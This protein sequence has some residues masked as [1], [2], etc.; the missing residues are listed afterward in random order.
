VK[1]TILAWMT[2]LAVAV[3]PAAAWAQH[4]HAPA[5]AP[6]APAPAGEP[7]D[8]EP[9]EGLEEDWLAL[10]DDGEWWLDQEGEVGGDAHMVMRNAHRAAGRGRA[11]L[12]HGR[13]HGMGMVGRFMRLDLTDAQRTKL[14]DLHEAA[15][16]KS[17]QRRAD[18]ELARMDLHKLMRAEN[19]NSASVS[20]A[21]DKVARLH[22]EGLKARF[23]TYMQA[24]AV[25]T[26]EQRK[27][28]DSP[29]GR[30]GAPAA[31]KGEG[32]AK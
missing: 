10:A 20:S 24:R 18:A 25:L 15:A 14:R 31:P 3:L 7:M 19:P 21:I 8:L 32:S 16:R 23:D 28:L 22:A 9:G 13:A 11:M 26:P 27:Q 12:H 5:P 4:G 6:H 1:R 17:V 29:A 30:P 2:W